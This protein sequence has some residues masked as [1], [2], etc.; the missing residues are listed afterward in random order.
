MEDEQILKTLKDFMNEKSKL[1]TIDSDINIDE[2][3]DD[4]KPVSLR[5]PRIIIRIL[6]WALKRI[7]KKLEKELNKK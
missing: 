3:D 4:F 2:L 6:I 1:N 7:L 5:L